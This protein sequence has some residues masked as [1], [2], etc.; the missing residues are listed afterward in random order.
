MDVPRKN[1]RLK[2]LNFGA[3]M[4]GEKRPL[5]KYMWDIAKNVTWGS[6]QTTSIPVDYPGTIVGIRWSSVC[7]DD[8]LENQHQTSTWVGVYHAG[9]TLADIPTGIMPGGGPGYVNIFTTGADVQNLAQWVHTNAGAPI[10][11]V[12][13]QPTDPGG[14]R[15]GYEPRKAIATMDRNEGRVKS[16]RKIQKGDY[17]TVWFRNINHQGNTDTQVR[18]VLEY[19]VLG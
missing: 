7:F 14:S 13:G 18:M 5:T 16:K 1:R 6:T 19:W 12:W 2:N 17:I 4:R 11:G 8:I 3:N 10:Y 15:P 9:S